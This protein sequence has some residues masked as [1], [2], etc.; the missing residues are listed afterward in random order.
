[1][2]LWTVLIM[3]FSNNLPVVERRLIG[4]IFWGNFGSLPGF[5][6][7]MTF[8]TFKDFGKW[9]RRIQWLNKYVKCTNGRLV[10][11]L[12]NLNEMPSIPQDFLDF[13]E[14]M[15]FCKSHS[16]ILSGS[17]LSTSL[18]RAWTLSHTRRLWFSSH[19]SWYVN[20]FSKQSTTE[21]AFLDG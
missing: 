11:C 2:C 5:R 20:W 1:M 6:N 18:N 10:R 7:V 19:K 16:L 3:T 15:S 8:A 13:K 14:L 21:L 12:R 4:C 9:E 17:L